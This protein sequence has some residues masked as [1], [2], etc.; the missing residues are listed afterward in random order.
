[1]VDRDPSSTPASI[2][3]KTRRCAMV[4]TPVFHPQSG[5][6]VDVEKP[7]IVDVVGGDLK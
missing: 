2:S 7:P 1:M 3:P 4:E 6:L 5:E